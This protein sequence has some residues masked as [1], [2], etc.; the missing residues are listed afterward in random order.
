[1]VEVPDAQPHERVRVARDRERFD[2]LREV[3]EGEVDVAD[4]RRAL[5]AQLAEGLD[6]WRR[7]CMVDDG[8]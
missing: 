1:M 2:E 3:G 4:L 5:E 7:A 6:R 8:R